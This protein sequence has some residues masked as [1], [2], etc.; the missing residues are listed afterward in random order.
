[1]IKNDLDLCSSE[2]IHIPGY[3]QAHGFLI[4]INKE[5]FITHYS[6]NLNELIGEECSYILGDKISSLNPLFGKT[7]NSNFIPDLI[8]LSWQSNEFK[9][10]NPYL[11]EIK[12]NYYNLLLSASGEDYILEFEPEASNLFIDLQN[13]VGSTL[14][15]ILV[16]RNLQTILETAVVQIRNII[17]YNRVMI[18]KFHDDGHGEVIAEDRDGNLETWLGLHYPATDIP[19]QAR[20]L[21]KKNYTRLIANVNDTPVSILSEKNGS[22]DL[23]NSSLR[24]VSPIHIRYLK[25]MGV[26]SSFSVSIIVENE[27]W[28]LVACHNYTPRFINFKQRETAKLIGQ[29]LSSCVELRNMENMQQEKLQFQNVIME[30]TRHL[31]NDTKIA[32]VLN[33]CAPIILEAFKASGIAFL[34]EGEIY[35]Y[36]EIPQK[37]IILQIGTKIQDSEAGIVSTENISEDFTDLFSEDKEFAGVL[38]CM[39]A[40]GLKDC[41][42]LFRPEIS[43]TVRWAGN[44]NKII[45]FDHIGQPFISP[46]NSFEQWIQQV[47]GKSKKWS[48][49]EIKTIVEIRDEIN[50][51]IGRK[52]TE[53]RILNQKLREAYA[54]L[55]SF[56]Y[57]VSHDLKTPLTA[58][59]A[60]ADLIIRKS[61]ENDVKIMSSKIVS[62]SE[63]LHKMI[64][65]VLEYSKVGQK[66][67]NKEKVNMSMMIEDITSQLL[68]G[69]LNHNL[70]IS[71][72]KTPD[73][74][75]D[76]I[77]IYQVFLNVIENA[78]K[79]SHKVEIPLVSVDGVIENKE[80][81]YRITDN[82]VGMSSEHQSMA[83]E[84][85]ERVGNTEEFE[86]TGVGLA[87]VKKIMLRHNA[88]ISIESSEGSG[89]TFILKFPLS[90]LGV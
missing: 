34:F 48:A 61:T 13:K 51:A 66:N 20:E 56:A 73:I 37:D 9:P 86:G 18:Y 87:T 58:I 5:G 52:T 70:Q 17:Q 23:T 45:N 30:V 49:V 43:Q 28:G 11:M 89:S 22:P 10:L 77:L 33:H 57:T 83:F 81:I 32:D 31:L 19:V 55:D 47:Q 16:N 80:I 84:L 1:M 3:I 38:G 41:I 54:E 69:K 60:Y 85:F 53:L 21:Y 64:N 46:R 72:D 27:L 67:I 50:I 75:G 24:A 36:G 65:T 6:E 35:S 8:N 14:S 59:K 26:S 79:Y 39:L 25:N 68:V 74:I 63:R 29:V 2:P 12:G 44:P 71:V 82:G 62:N 76:P 15:Q 90:I 7:L 78:V 4:V 42:L 40:E 88:N